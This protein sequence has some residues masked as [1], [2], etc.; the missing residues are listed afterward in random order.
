MMISDLPTKYNGPGNPI[1]IIGINGVLLPNTLVDLV[2][3][4]NAMTYKTVISLQLPRLKTTPILLE[5]VDKSIFKPIGSLEY[6]VVT[7]SSW[8]YPID[9]VVISPKTSRPGHPM[10]LGRP[11]LET[12]NTIIGCRNGKMTISNGSHNQTVSIF[13]PTKKTSEVPLWLENSYGNEDCMFLLLTIEQ[14]RGF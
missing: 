14:S 8:K 7:N 6:I 2:A 3:A 5:M 13:P 10:V 12:T 4:I 9:F 11:W 1:I